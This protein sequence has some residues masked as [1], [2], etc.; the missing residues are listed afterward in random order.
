MKSATKLAL[1]VAV[2]L[3]A[4]WAGFQAGQPTRKQTPGPDASVALTRLLT[5]P[6]TDPAGRPRTLAS[7]EG[8]IRVI[9]LW[10]TWC[11]PCREEMP[12]FALIHQQFANKNVQFIGLALDTREAV[13]N[14]L[15]GIPP[16]YPIL[17]GSTDLI[18]LTPELGNTAMGLPFTFILDAQGRL[19]SQKL[20]LW[21]EADLRAEL[22]RL[23]VA[24]PAEQLPRP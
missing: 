14:F 12:A 5:A 11:P 17:V 7:W 18:D 6:Y 19:V 15:R 22:Q 21:S 9:N 16:T 20:G 13:T 8:K 2:A 3:L 1:A 10:A 24:T 4:A 23:T